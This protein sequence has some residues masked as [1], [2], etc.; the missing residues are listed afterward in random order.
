MNI[1]LFLMSIWIPKFVLV[2]ELK[3]TSK[4]TNNCIDNILESYSIP[5][6]DVENNLRGN[7]EEQR[8]ILANSHNIRLD[9]LIEVLGFDEALKV[10]RKEL[11]KAGYMMGSEIKKRLNVKNVND[12]IIAARII[13][14]VLGINFTVEKRGKDIILRIISCELSTLYSA[15]T[16]R[17][18]SAVDE[19]V[20]KGLN[21]KIDM[22]FTTRIT[23]GAEECAACLKIKS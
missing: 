14:K 13:Y 10:G 7:L 3:K 8:L 4:I 21:D 9:T 1:K 2:N 22:N 12:A 11:F 18:M 6:P 19:G 16:C 5:I 23:E 17:I 20:L 15:E